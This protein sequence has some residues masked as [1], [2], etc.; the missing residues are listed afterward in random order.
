MSTKPTD[1]NSTSKER[2]TVANDLFEKGYDIECQPAIR[3]IVVGEVE[4]QPRRD[5]IHLRLGFFERN[6][7][8]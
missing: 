2:R 3:R 8:F 5:G 1:P 4:T 7:G 6:L